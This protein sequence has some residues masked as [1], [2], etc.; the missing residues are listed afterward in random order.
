MYNVLL[1]DYR[2]RAGRWS[3]L[4]LALPVCFVLLLGCDSGTAPSIYDPDRGSLPD[5]VIESV[6]PEGRALAGV[7]IVTLTGQNFSN[8]A[9]DN[10]VYFGDARADVVEASGTQLQV[11]APNTPDPELE[12]RAVVIGA[13]NFSN[14]VSYGLDPPFVEFGEV[15]DFEDVFGITTDPA[16]NLY[17]SLLAFSLPVGIVR[18]SA[19]GERSD[20]ITP[21]TFVWVDMEFGPDDYLY[22]VRSVRAIF[23]FAGSGASPEVFAVI[24][25]STVR[26]NTLTIDPDG[27]IW[28]AGDN[29]EIYSV[30]PA[31]D[32]NSYAFEAD[33]R[34][35]ALFGDHLYVAG[36]QGD[37][38]GVWRFGMDSNH[39]LREPEM[40]FD[41]T[42][43]NGATAYALEFSA[44]G[45]LFVGTD[46]TDPVI[47]VDSEGTGQVLYPGVFEQSV[48]Q[49]SWG[50]DLQLY[51]ATS[52]TETAAA[53]IIRITT[54]D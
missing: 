27:G 35:I 23:R 8:E 54:R 42:T 25:A 48:R 16:G 38:S 12:I 22:A 11:A 31:G 49:F 5:P 18:I 28:A 52:S 41:V 29:T 20:Y 32:I 47:V 21:S 33:V 4:I 3:P 36:T 40:F 24:P 30:T 44:A 19:E 15:K 17:V 51:A 45:Q 34:D 1:Y 50:L 2:Y 9:T 6:A 14:R 13:E 37:L 39:I 7:D 53:G 46:A 26:L 10:L 43:F